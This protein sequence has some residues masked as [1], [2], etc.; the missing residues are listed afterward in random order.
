MSIIEITILIVAGI[1]V[2]FI[3]TLAGGGSV[4]S[5]SVFMFMGLS[6]TIANGT[7]RITI[8]MQTLTA[9]ASFKQQKVLEHKKAIILSIPALIGSFIGA[10]IA[11]DIND[12]I[13]ERVFAGVMIVMLFFILFK[14]QKY[15]Y[16]REEI[17]KKKINIWQILIFFFIGIYGGFI[18]VGMGYFLLA[19]IVLGAGFD[20]V[21]ANAVKVFIALSIVL[22]ALTIFLINSQVQ[23]IPGL[24]MGAGSIVGAL[25]ASRLAVKKGINF[26]RYV[27]IVLICIFF[28]H[29]SGILN[30]KELLQN[31]L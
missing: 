25:I 20:L 9:V 27:I 10:L 5:L 3:N 16:G 24:I 17:L 4:I 2:G 12:I 26:V 19:G 11:V 13:F 8:A 18:Q 31:I 30:I 29:F 21:K 23:W 15:L 6:P 7:N 1:F 28:I 14:P 22:V